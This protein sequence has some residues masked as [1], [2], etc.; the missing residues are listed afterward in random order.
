MNMVIVK[1]TMLSAVKRVGEFQTTLNRKIASI[2]IRINNVIIGKKI[3]R[4]IHG[5]L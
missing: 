5:S 3:K 2:I 1:N 4:L